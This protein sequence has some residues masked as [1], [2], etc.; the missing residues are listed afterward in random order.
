VGGSQ[1]T[2]GDSR[3]GEKGFLVKRLVAWVSIGVLVGGFFTTVSPVETG[4]A[5]GPP[6]DDG[7]PVIVIDCTDATSIR[8]S[9]Q[10]S[11][12]AQPAGP[13]GPVEFVISGTR[14]TGFLMKAAANTTC[15]LGRGLGAIVGNDEFSDGDEYGVGVDPFGRAPSGG[16]SIQGDDGPA[17][18]VWVNHCEEI[19]EGSGIAQDPWRVYSDDDF[20][21]IGK[22]YKETVEFEGDDVEVSLVNRCALWGH[23]RQMDSFSI[24]TSKD[25]PKLNVSGAAVGI[26]T[27]VYDGDHHTIDITRDPGKFNV[28]L[29]DFVY[30]DQWQRTVPA[31]IKK[32]R[33]TGEIHTDKTGV[34]SLANQVGDDSFGGRPGVVTEVRSSVKITISNDS[35]FGRF[36]G[37]VARGANEGLIQYSAF[38]GAIE[39]SSS[40]ADEA[41]RVV[42]GG[43]VGDAARFVIRDSYST[44]SISVNSPVRDIENGPKVGGL[45]GEVD[46]ARGILTILRSYFAGSIQNSCVGQCAPLVAGGLVG[47]TGELV[48]TAN[49]RSSF[50]LNTV[51]DNAY[52]ED[53]IIADSPEE[54]REQP[55]AY[56]TGA[57]ANLPVAVPVSS[58]L[59]RNIT[60]FQSKQ[61]DVLGEPSGAGDLVVAASNGTLAEQDYRWAIE[62][63]DV[64]TFVAQ[65]RDHPQPI[66]GETVTFKPGFNRLLW[67][68]QPSNV[69]TATY[70]TEGSTTQATGYPILG[71]VW[72]ICAD[73]NNGYPTLVWEGYGCPVS[74]QDSAAGAIV[75]GSPD[76]KPGPTL[77]ATGTPEG[78]AQW[79]VLASGIIA[80]LGAWFV[81]WSHRR[82]H[83]A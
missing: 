63:G 13:G 34:G 55:S 54:V 46:P 75:A 40:S 81:A 24:D 56:T 15:T 50:W 76:A 25:N 1:F 7:P 70:S 39:W 10:S 38:T 61:G 47:S 20:F 77:A 4:W 67:G 11:G 71:R 19:E 51:A 64:D 74:T 33:L 72:E 16:F 18:N 52:G 17:I 79:G 43:L 28:P 6:E 31:V 65:K 3:C 45:V 9:L 66:V 41:N 27:G 5:S 44:G 22:T 26:F 73:E 42:I 8:Q 36:G 68:S 80:L 49:I 29:F 62:A 60:T 21:E 23:Y 83:T 53:P 58:S 82:R 35:T 57:S 48:N 32:L 30:S 14:A 78:A 2:R 37:L 12:I 69:P 59:L